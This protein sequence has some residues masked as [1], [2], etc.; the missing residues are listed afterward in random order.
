MN[1]DWQKLK[2][3]IHLEALRF[4]FYTSSPRLFNKRGIYLARMFLQNKL[5]EFHQLFSV[6]GINILIQI[7]HLYQIKTK[8]GRE[9]HCQGLF[10]GNIFRNTIELSQKIHVDLVFLVQTEESLYKILSI[11]LIPNTLAVKDS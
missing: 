3:Y 2:I 7:C 10:V 9:I 11:D 5:H 4:L 1:E 8:T 6:K